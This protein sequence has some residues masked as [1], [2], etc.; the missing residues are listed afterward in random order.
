M[1]P[2]AGFTLVELMV[3]IALFTIILSMGI[4][5]YSA[6]KTKHDIDGQTRTLYRN[7]SFARME[8]YVKKDVA[9]I[10]WGATA[11][12]SNYEVRVD[13]NGDGDIKDSADQK[14]MDVTSPYPWGGGSG[15]SLTFDGRGFAATGKT[16]HVSGVSVPQGVLSC[17]VV[18][19]T[20]IRMG[21]WD[22]S[23][24]QAK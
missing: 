6:W 12:F 9:G 21:F 11:G 13:S 16:F 17:V 22:G 5:A 3:V 14:I 8:A 23:S 18:S 15:D 1:R 7:L 24:C 10:Y 4:P 20:R 2:K 19:R